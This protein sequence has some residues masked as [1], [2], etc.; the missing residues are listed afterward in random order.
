MIAQL[1]GIFNEFQRGFHIPQICWQTH[2][3]GWI[4]TIL[5]GFANGSR[6]AGIQRMDCPCH[7]GRL[8]IHLTG[9]QCVQHAAVTDHD[10][11]LCPAVVKVLFP[12]SDFLTPL[13]HCVPHLPA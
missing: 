4:G 9:A 12:G 11:G 10:K 13:F 7:S 8:G 1:K 5:P 2:L 3:E 6:P